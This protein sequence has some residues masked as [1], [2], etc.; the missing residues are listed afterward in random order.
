MAKVIKREERGLTDIEE[1]PAQMTLNRRATIIEKSSVQ[2]RT[3]AES[4]RKR[5]Q[6]DANTLL[7]EARDEATRL[8]EE[9]H[10]QGYDEGRNQGSAE[11][12]EIVASATQRLR[13]LEH[14]AIPQLKE[15]VISIAKKVLGREFKSHPDT[16]ID[17]IRH[18]LAEK[19]RQRREISLRVNPEDLAVLKAN[20]SSLMEVLSRSPELG[21]HEDP[22]VK[23]YG[24][25]IE[26]EAGTIDAQLETQLTVLERVL[27]Q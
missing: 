2:A 26:T 17:L 27:K 15:L 20:K 3:E 25:I 23:R 7:Q 24:V 19:A 8:H 1:T 12:T 22:E 9:A 21:L 10:Q 14:Q 13:T 18:A 4:I 11:L 6:A 16:I 5:A